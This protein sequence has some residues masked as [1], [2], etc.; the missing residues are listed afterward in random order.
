MNIQL[1]KA[2]TV[3]EFGSPLVERTSLLSPPT[4]KQVRVRIRACG[5]CH[6][7]LHFHEGH[8]NLGA[9]NSL[10]LSD[11]G[12]TPPFVLGH[13]P[14][15]EIVDFGADSG[16]DS[17]DLGRAVIVYPWIGC[18]HCEL[19][20]NGQDHQCA[21]P[22]VIGM[23]QPGG[24][25][26]H[27]IVPDARFL[28]DATGVDPLLAGS[29][30]CSGLTSYS[31]LKKVERLREDWIGIIGVGGVGMMALAVAKAMG[32]RKVAAIDVNDQRLGVARDEFGADLIINSKAPEAAQ[33][34]LDATGGLA[35]VIDFVGS[36][37]TA[38]LAIGLLKINGELVVVGMF[39]GELRVPLPILS[40]KQLNLRGSF[41]G[42][43]D[44]LN[45][46]MSYVRAGKVKPIPAVAMPVHQVNDAITQLKAGKV[47]G[48]IVLTH[49]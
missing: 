28:I 24:Q 40:I 25:A 13:E 1:V 35:G 4:G 29:Y 10:A 41:V 45:E 46:L 15:G 23:Q 39:G 47:D 11:L 18:G 2:Q 27:L 48:R 36:T 5:L 20:N 44:E 37:D 49:D 14:S 16:L 21:Q 42:S 7:D 8:L 6:S 38:D 22:Q 3:I 12:V 31:A 43:V 19:C 17:A 32:F 26:D 9:G 30:A 34:L 33:T